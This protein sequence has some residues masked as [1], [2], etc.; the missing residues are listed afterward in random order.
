[1]DAKFEHAQ[2]LTGIYEITSTSTMG[3][4]QSQVNTEIDGGDVNVMTGTSAGLN[5]VIAAPRRTFHPEI[6]C[7]S[8]KIYTG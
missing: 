3:L 5:R 7:T 2:S 4:Q 1:M 6:G 8:D